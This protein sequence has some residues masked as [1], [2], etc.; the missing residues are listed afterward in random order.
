MTETSFVQPVYAINCRD[1]R[2][3]NLFEQVFSSEMKIPSIKFSLLC[4]Y[5]GFIGLCMVG[6]FSDSV[7]LRELAN[8]IKVTM[9]LWF[10]ILAGMLSPVLYFTQHEQSPWVLT[11]FL[12]LTLLL[13]PVYKYV[14]QPSSLELDDTRIRVNW[15]IGPLRWAQSF[16]WT[17]IASVYFSGTESGNTDEWRF[18]IAS[19]EAHLTGVRLGCLTNNDDRMKLLE[20]TQKYCPNAD[21]DHR[22]LQAWTPAHSNSYTEIWLQSL[23]APPKRARL[24]PLEEGMQLQDGKYQIKNVLATG[25][26]AVVYLAFPKTEI[27]LPPAIK[28]QAA[29]KQLRSA[30]ADGRAN[31]NKTAN[32]SAGSQSAP[33]ESSNDNAPGGADFQAPSNESI[34]EKKSNGTDGAYA[35]DRSASASSAVQAELKPSTHESLIVI[36]EMIIPVY[37]DEN[38]RRKELDRF[39]RESRLLSNLDCDHI[40]KLL[41]YFI[42]DHR[43]YLV[44]EY[45]DGDS[46]VGLISKSGALPESKV[47]ELSIQMCATLSYLHGLSPPVVHRDFTPDNL[48]LTS[49]GSLKL[50]DFNVAQEAKFTT[51]ATVVGKHAYLPPEQFRGKPCPQSDIY[52]L[53]GT[54]YFLSTGSEPEPISSAHPILVNENVSEKLDRIVARATEPE[55]KD[56]YPSIAELQADLLALAGME[57]KSGKI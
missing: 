56:R 6:I 3:M 34:Y 9:L 21:V 33:S 51:T 49:D 8:V 22:I 30:Q 50:I 53:G 11:L 45:I 54:L 42:E 39:D 16:H 31:A 40:V 24:A 57:V 48:I 37:G 10:G 25:G 47:L 19:N 1:R 55:L 14:T 2:L 36:K 43:G 27:A 28:V 29:E 35:P 18:C 5:A 32:G 26:Q 44:M 52:A 13:I 23:A 38:L 12:P 46:L 20:Y 41:D 4:S 17:E 7:G 15:A